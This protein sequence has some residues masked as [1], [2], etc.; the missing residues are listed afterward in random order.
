MQTVTLY[1]APWQKRMLKDFMPS[2]SIKG[3]PIKDITQ[4]VVGLGPNVCLASYLIPMDGIKLGDWVMHLT[5]EQMTMVKQ[6]MK[7]R[8]PI[9]AIN[10]SPEFLKSG[11]IKFR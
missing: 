7:T 2:S 1:L 10:I 8:T 4:I 3:K 11:Q 5:D 9:T 6:N